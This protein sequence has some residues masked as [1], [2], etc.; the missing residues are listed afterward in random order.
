MF[1]DASE[2]GLPQFKLA[3][4]NRGKTFYTNIAAHPMGAVFCAAAITLVDLGH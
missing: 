2:V 4:E 3:F 1:A